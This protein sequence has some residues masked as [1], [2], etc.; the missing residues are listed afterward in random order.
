MLVMPV[1][2]LLLASFQ[3]IF[4]ASCAPTEIVVRDTVYLNRA[5][6]YAYQSDVVALPGAVEIPRDGSSPRI[7]RERAGGTAR[8]VVLSSTG[9]RVEVKN[10]ES[11]ALVYDGI[12][13]EN[14]YLRYESTEDGYA[15]TLATRNEFVVLDFKTLCQIYIIDN[16][17]NS[18][19]SLPDNLRYEQVVWTPRSD[20][21]W[22]VRVG[23][24]N[25][26]CRSEA[27]ENLEKLRR[28]EYEKSVPRYRK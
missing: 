23:S 8:S 27:L 11:V 3:G 20:G 2:A 18:A 19:V 24:V 1:A 4:L 15:L 28:G 13:T 16:P 21:L 25:R 26:G 17:A 9:Q 12:D 22:E 7:A 14:S 5:P 10:G 6:R